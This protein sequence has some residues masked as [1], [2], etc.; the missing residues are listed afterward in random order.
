MSHGPT[1]KSIQ[2]AP[3]LTLASYPPL[4]RQELPES[5][6]GLLLVP[7]VLLCVFRQERQGAGRG[8]LG[9]WRRLPTWPATCQL[10]GAGL[11]ERERVTGSGQVEVEA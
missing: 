4:P 3:P 6:G 1:P 5:R 7:H 9:P 2:S 11:S 8:A 10:P